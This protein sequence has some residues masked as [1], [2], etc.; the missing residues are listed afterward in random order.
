MKAIIW[1]ELRE[2]LKWAALGLVVV[3]LV[4]A[5]VASEVKKYGNNPLGDDA[6]TLMLIGAALMCLLGFMQVFVESRRDQWAFLAHRPTTLTRVFFGKAIAAAI[7]Y[8]PAMTVLWTVFVVWCARPGHIARPFDWRLSLPGYVDILVGFAFYFAGMLTGLRQAKWYASKALGLAVPIILI[9]LVCFAPEFWHALVLVAVATGLV[10]VAAWGSF[11]N[12]GGYT[13]QRRISKLALG[14]TVA[15]GIGAAGALV[16]AVLLETMRPYVWGGWGNQRRYESYSLAR[17]GTVLRVE[18]SG[19]EVLSVVDLEGNSVE[20]YQDPELRSRESFA[21]TTVDYWIGVGLSSDILPDDWR[22]RS[23][24]YRSGARRHDIAFWPKQSSPNWFYSYDDACFIEYD[25]NTR[26]PLGRLGPNGYVPEGK[27]LPSRFGRRVI[28]LG[29]DPDLRAFSEGVYRFDWDERKVEKV[30]APEPGDSICGAGGRNQGDLIAVRTRDT[31]HL[32]NKQGD[33][34]MTIPVDGNGKYASVLFATLADGKRTFA[35]YYPHMRGRAG[36][37]GSSLIVE[38]ANDG[39]ALSRQELPAIVRPITSATVP[40]P[41]RVVWHVEPLLVAA[42][43]PAGDMFWYVHMGAPEPPGGVLRNVL[44]N[45]LLWIEIRTVLIWSVV[46][47]MLNLF[48]C[49]RRSFGRSAM[50]AWAVW[51]FLL[52]PTGLLLLLCIQDWPARVACA[53][54]AKKRRVDLDNCEH[55]GVPFP[56][57]ALDGTEVFE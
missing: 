22:R 12:G 54:C 21:K 40:W 32:M 51:G 19:H 3:G 8:L 11:V 37:R 55:C 5:S 33:R 41:L 38:L 42:G 16:G 46:F 47:A 45:R 48:V 7:L 53:G 43:K 57:P 17:D 10:G 26:L 30:F 52:G 49:W 18:Q 27:G 25:R 14:V 23:Y 39:T 31:M 36:V 34:L 24:P 20:K 56:R 6:P 13:G 1:K 29:A 50:A 4:L 2:N 44:D 9:P 35:W 15:I 28:S